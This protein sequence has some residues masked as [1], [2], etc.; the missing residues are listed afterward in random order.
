VHVFRE[1]E[2]YMFNKDK[3]P[4]FLFG[5]NYKSVA[6]IAYAFGLYFC[7][8]CHTFFPTQCPMAS[9]SM[10]YGLERVHLSAGGCSTWSPSPIG[11][12]FK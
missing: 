7:E 8:C 6:G 10:R 1:V 3:M 5:H 4:C 2:D 11:N 9:L 12:I